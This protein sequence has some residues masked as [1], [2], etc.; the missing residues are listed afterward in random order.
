MDKPRLYPDMNRLG[1][2]RRVIYRKLGFCQWL[3]IWAQVDASHV[4]IAHTKGTEDLLVPIDPLGRYARIVSGKRRQVVE[5]RS[6]G[7]LK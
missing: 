3:Y 4:G 5:R 2:T 6:V 7:A 1:P